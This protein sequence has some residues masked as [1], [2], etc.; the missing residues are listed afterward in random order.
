MEFKGLTYCY[1]D[2]FAD[3]CVGCHHPAT[4]EQCWYPKTSG[5][6]LARGEYFF[7]E[8]MYPLGK[9]AQQLKSHAA[10]A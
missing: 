4:G 9:T 2:Q 10:R 5:H 7:H 3:I 6:S 1:F 8:P